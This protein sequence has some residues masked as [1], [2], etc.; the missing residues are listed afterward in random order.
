M[1]KGTLILNGINYSGGGSGG[2][3]GTSDYNSLFNQPKINGVTL[4]GNK[5]AEDLGLAT[6]SEVNALADIVGTVNTM[7]EEV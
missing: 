5:T 1:N 2:S 3:G 4:T 6:S 7:L